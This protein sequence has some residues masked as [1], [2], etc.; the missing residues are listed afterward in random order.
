[1]TVDRVKGG[2]RAPPSSPGWA[3]FTIMMEFSLEK[4]WP[5]PLCVLCEYNGDL[6]S[7]LACEV[8]D[9]TALNEPKITKQHRS[10]SKI[11]LILTVWPPDQV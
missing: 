3:D 10:T 6:I 8:D 4:K 9:M 11:Q 2:W 1:V 5:L 7:T